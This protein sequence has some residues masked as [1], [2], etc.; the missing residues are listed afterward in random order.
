MKKAKAKNKSKAKNKKTKVES[1]P[2]IVINGEL[3]NL[4]DHLKQIL[5]QSEKT[6]EQLDAIINQR[7]VNQSGEK[8]SKNLARALQHNPCFL[9]KEG[10]W[11]L[12]NRGQ[13]CND[14]IYQWLCTTGYPL[15]YQEL[16][17]MA[18]ENGVEIG[19]ERDL[20]WDGRFIRL[21]NGKW[22]LN[23]WKVLLRP[24]REVADWVSSYIKERGQPLNLSEVLQTLN[25][26]NL[27]LPLLKQILTED[28]RFLEVGPE[29]ISTQELYQA[30]LEILSAKD[31]LEPFRQGEINVLQEAEFIMIVNDD[32]RSNRR[33][34]IL[35]SWDVE[36]GTLTLTPRLAKIFRELPPVSFLDFQLEDKTLGLWYLK[37]QQTLV[38]LAPWYGEKGLESGHIVELSWTKGEKGYQFSLSFTGEREAEVYSEGVRLKKLGKLGQWVKE[39]KP[40]RETVLIK[41]L[42]LYPEGLSKEAIKAAFKAFGLSCAKLE[43]ILRAYPFFEE[44]EKEHWRCNPAMKDSYFEMLDQIR[45]AQEEL[46]AAREEAASALAEIKVLQQ[47]KDTLQEELAYLQ[48]HYREEQ[49]LYQQKLSEMAMENEHWHLEN[50]RLKSELNRLKQREEELLQDIEA[51]GE[52][53]IN[54]RQEKNKLKVKIEQ[55]ENKLVQLQGNLNRIVEDAQA[56]ITRLQKMLQEKN[57]QLESLQY[58]H[59][60]MHRNMNRLHEERREMKR[61]LSLW[62]VRLVLAIL[63]LTQRAVNRKMPG[64]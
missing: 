35:S 49:A 24:A 28:G 14:A 3:D 47:E 36:R 52:Q 26:A 61:K 19:P 21:K 29:L 56:E 53:L 2:E 5:A 45:I 13:E 50:A 48:N 6:M 40:D 15:N 18:E 64:Y 33:R 44:G 31:P 42:E 20:V 25:D 37:E 59:Q 51:Q 41:L 12:D 55:L 32:T 23:G 57:S 11:S 62:P 38:G 1:L 16:K 22:G 17:A 58:A 10:K 27:D 7:L 60:E 39:E 8:L 54:L 46:K 4:T 9:E 34:H 30:Q 43:Q 63:S